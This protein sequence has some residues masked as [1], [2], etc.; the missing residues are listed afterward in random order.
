MKIK[1][2]FAAE[3]DPEIVPEEYFFERFR[4]WRAVEL[5]KSDWTQLPDVTTNREAW[6][7]YRQALRDLPSSKD[8]VNAI[9]P[10]KPA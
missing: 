4:N 7:E 3:R 5:S 9:L 1:E 6:A 10:I 8:F 2:F